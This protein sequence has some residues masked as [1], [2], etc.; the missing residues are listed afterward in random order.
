MIVTG[1]DFMRALGVDTERSR[2]S[3]VYPYPQDE[4]DP[5]Y[6]HHEFVIGNVLLMYEHDCI[7]GFRVEQAPFER[8]RLSWWVR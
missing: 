4:R 6:W 5:L 1:H 2:R 3:S 7:R 8:P